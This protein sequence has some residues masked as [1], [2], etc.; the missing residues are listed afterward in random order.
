MMPD[1]PESAA[2]IAAPGAARAPGNE[3]TLEPED[4][5]S[6]PFRIER[7]HQNIYM[8]AA[9][10]GTGEG[11]RQYL[12]RLMKMIPGEVVGLYLIGSGFIP[13]E[14]RWLL[15]VWTIVCVIAVVVIRRYG[16]ADPENGLPPQGIPVAVSTVAFL[17]WVYTLGGPFR[18][19]KVAGSDLHQP[20][21]GS[22]L[23]LSWSFFIPIFYRDPGAPTPKPS[24]TAGGS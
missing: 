10:N 21:V 15:V 13:Q 14:W 20:V 7:S 12:D 6:A 19:Y 17:I 16:T 3:N 1:W 9:A 4:C 2:A 22:L 23:V 8:V 24:P 5:M 11:F 18:G